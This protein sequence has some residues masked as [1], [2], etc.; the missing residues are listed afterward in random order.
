[1]THQGRAI[2]D[3]GSLPEPRRELLRYLSTPMLYPYQFCFIDH[4]IQIDQK[5]VVDLHE[6]MCSI[7]HCED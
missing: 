3:P 5:V 4:R 2:N 1:M 6:S 7:R